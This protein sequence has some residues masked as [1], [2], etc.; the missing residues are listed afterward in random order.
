MPTD[1]SSATVVQSISTKYF[2]REERLCFQICLLYDDSR[3]LLKEFD[4]YESYRSV[5]DHLVSA[6]NANRPVSVDLG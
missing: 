6:I 3:H 5:H 2:Y 1:Q 4:D